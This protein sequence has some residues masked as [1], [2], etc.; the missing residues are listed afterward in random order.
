ML[1]EC[2]TVLGL[3]ILLISL[4]TP[5]AQAHGQLVSSS[6]VANSQVSALPEKVRL[7]FDGNLQSFEGRVVNVIVVE[8]SNGEQIDAGDSIVAGAVLTVTLRDRSESGKFHV[9]Y[10][11]VSGDGH[12]VSGDYYF[13]VSDASEGT[14]ATSHR[15]MQAP[16]TAVPILISPKPEGSKSSWTRHQGGV[17]LGFFAFVALLIWRFINKR[18]REWET[19]ERIE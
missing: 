14:S 12:P 7:E 10:R 2:R 17:L 9:S 18:R 8:D 11:V 16:E 6:P 3:L 1:R 5:S 15:A 19:V 13:T 4:A